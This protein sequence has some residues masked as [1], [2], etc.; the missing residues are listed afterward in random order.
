MV[1]IAAQRLANDLIEENNLRE[2]LDD[3]QLSYIV[4]IIDEIIK[5]G[6][7]DGVD[8]YSILIRDF[9]SKNGKDDKVDIKELLKYMDTMEATLNEDV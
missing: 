4:Q 2:C 1:L 5:Y 6:I 7:H 9:I 8:K 3:S